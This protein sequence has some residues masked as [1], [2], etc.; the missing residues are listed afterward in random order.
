MVLLPKKKQ[1]YDYYLY[2]LQL[3]LLFYKYKE[4]EL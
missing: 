3:F 1:I 4:L 2:K